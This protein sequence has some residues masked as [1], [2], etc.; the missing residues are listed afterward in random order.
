MNKYHL[1]STAGKD[2][3]CLDPNTLADTQLL[4]TF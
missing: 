3:V 4:K 2:L 1:L